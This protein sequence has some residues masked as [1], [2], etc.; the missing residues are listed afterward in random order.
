MVVT[1]LTEALQRFQI[2]Q[3]NEC[4][5]HSRN[6]VNGKNMNRKNVNRKKCE[7][8]C[9]GGKNVNRKKCEPEKM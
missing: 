1:M 3:S 9:K 4:C 7:Q 8:F 5:M 2:I 6:G